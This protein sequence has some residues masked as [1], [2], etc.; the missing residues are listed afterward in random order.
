MQEG[1]EIE[2][3]RALGVGWAA[4]RSVDADSQGKLKGQKF[5]LTGTLSSPRAQFKQRIEAAG[6][7]V[8]GSLSK[9]TDFLVAGENPGS[10]LQ[11][12]SDLGV[13]IVDES[14]LEALL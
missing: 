4:V 3:L 14:G 13:E 8:V 9:K 11:K 10:K 6:G 7:K 2:R 5:V 1:A 12:A